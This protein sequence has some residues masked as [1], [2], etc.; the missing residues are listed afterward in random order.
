MLSILKR[1]I[2]P[3]FEHLGA[4]LYLL[5]LALE[6]GTLRLHL[7]LVVDDSLGRFAPLGRPTSASPTTRRGIDRIEFYVSSCWKTDATLT[8]HLLAHFLKDDGGVKE[9]FEIILLANRWELEAIC[10]RY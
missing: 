5:I 7:T 2:D 10:A 6:A 8:L 4:H 3:R 1:F 9:A